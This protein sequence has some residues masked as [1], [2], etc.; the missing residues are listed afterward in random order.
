MNEIQENVGFYKIWQEYCKIQVKFLKTKK[1]DFWLLTV[2]S[3][4]AIVVLSKYLVDFFML[5]RFFLAFSVG[6]EIFVKGLSQFS[7][8]VL[9]PIY[10]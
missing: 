3:R 5:S 9:C 1:W 2:L 7:F 4:S 8:R 6:V 10:S